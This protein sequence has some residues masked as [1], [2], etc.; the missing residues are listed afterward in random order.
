[1]TTL[2]SVS[3]TWV[4]TRGSGAV[5]LLLLT[6]TLVLGIAGVTRRRSRALPRFVVEGLHRNLALLAVAFVAVHV[7][8]TV[9]DT[10][11]SISLADA[12]VPFH[13][14]YKSFW[15]GLGAIGFDL[16]LALVATGLL[17][18]QIGHRAWRAT[19]WLAYA[20]WPVALAHTL[21]TGTDAAQPWLLGLSLACIGAVAIALVT[22]LAY[23]GA[24]PLGAPR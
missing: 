3:A 22:R 17:R 1:M 20:C 24:G 10:F 4:L 12:V 19:H 23:A 14:T 16:L 7:V 21:G 9:L 2:A 5:S 8:T 6:A 18:R 15:L 11:V 13:G